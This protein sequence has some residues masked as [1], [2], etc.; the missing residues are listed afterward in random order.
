MPHDTRGIPRGTV[1]GVWD[2]RPHGVVHLRRRA[3]R[4]RELSGALAPAPFSSAG[5][6]GP[7]RPPSSRPTLPRSPAR[8]VRCWRS[9]I[10]RTGLIIAT[11][12][13]SRNMQATRYGRTAHTLARPAKKALPRPCLL[14]RFFGR[15][16]QIATMCRK[17]RLRT[18]RS[19]LLLL[20]LSEFCICMANG[21][22]A[23]PIRS[24]AT[25]RVALI[26]NKL[27][28]AH[29]LCSRAEPALPLVRCLHVSLHLTC[30]GV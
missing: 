7:G 9:D 30:G 22:M 1:Q 21:C 29:E 6:R 2:A 12:G 25:N 10:A 19:H 17:R 8:A 16:A 20:S 18:A 5:M 11:G 13:V 24:A 23:A 28:G 26:E 27:T 15:L 4:A 3:S 14:I